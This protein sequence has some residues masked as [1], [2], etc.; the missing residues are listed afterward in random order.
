MNKKLLTER[1]MECIKAYAEAD[2]SVTVAA[3]N[4]H[5]HRNTFTYHLCNAKKK[6]GLDPQ[7]FYDL[8]YMLG[9]TEDHRHVSQMQREDIYREAIAKYGAAHQINKF[10]EELGEFLT[11]YGRYLNGEDN[12]GKLAEE[13]CDLTIMVE[14]LRIVFG[15]ED[16]VVD[17]MDYKVRRLSN[18]V[19]GKENEDGE[20]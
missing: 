15:I 12:E 18:R 4:T 14:Q 19:H 16:A 7:K 13:L 1:E 3:E 6:T 10:N 2:M 11:E 5:C 17:Q 9:L 20:A 8:A